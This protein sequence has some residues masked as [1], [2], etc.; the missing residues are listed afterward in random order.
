MQA[1]PRTSKPALPLAKP[2][3]R[4]TVSACHLPASPP[5]SPG[6]APFSHPRPPLQMQRHTPAAAHRAGWQR[7]GCPCQVGLAS[8]PGSQPAQPPAWR[9]PASGGL[10]GGAR[11]CPGVVE[12]DLHGMRRRT[13]ASR[14]D[15]EGCG[16]QRKAGPGAWAA[17]GGFSGRV[18]NQIGQR[19]PSDLRRFWHP[20]KTT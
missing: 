19:R 15:S 1:A 4:L 3:T 13:A 18:H 7:R 6:P 16:R 20:G 8:A 11:A 2:S 17:G 9:R 12:P 14:H 10:Q 5:A